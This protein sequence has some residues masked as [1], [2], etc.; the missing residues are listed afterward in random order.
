[1]AH[2]LE[3]NE[4]GSASMFFV[5]E[6]PWHGLGTKLASPPTSAEAMKAAKMDWTVC[7]RPVF[8]AD[9]NGKPLEDADTKYSAIVRESDG[10]RLGMAT[11][12]YKLVQNSEAFGFFDP[13]VTA[14]LAS[15]ETAGVLKEG[16]LVWVMAKLDV[17]N[18]IVEGDSIRNYAILSMGHDGARSVGGTLSSVR[19]VC[20]NTLGAAEAEGVKLFKLRHTKTVNE[21]IAVAGLVFEEIVKNLEKRTE[22]LRALA[23]KQLDSKGLMDYFEQV[24]PSDSKQAENV[25]ARLMVLADAG[26]GTE[27]PGVRGTLWGAY[28]AVTEYT[29][30]ERNVPMK[31][32]DAYRAIDQKQT[33]IPG[34]GKVVSISAKIAARRLESLWFGSAAELNQKA[35]NTALDLLA[36]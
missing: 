34:T 10:K 29:S 12:D 21:Q 30:H 16:A 22:A 18:E 4:D 3:I 5:G 32:L 31:A 20:A 33:A 24:F 11:K 17:E 14:N 6:T 1:M 8:V 9:A 25:R 13:L 27:I 23:G 2:E 7:Q 28:N 35:L 26:R 15:Y 36:A 19:V